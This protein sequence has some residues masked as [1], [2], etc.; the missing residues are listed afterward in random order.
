MCQRR[1][2]SKPCLT[3]RSLCAADA[4]ALF[5]AS[6]EAV[7]GVAGC[8]WY[9]QTHQGRA[10]KWATLLLKTAFGLEATCI[11][12][13]RGRQALFRVVMV[14]RGEGK[15]TRHEVSNCTVNVPTVY[16]L[17]GTGEGAMGST[18]SQTCSWSENLSNHRGRSACGTPQHLRI[19]WGCCRRMGA[20]TLGCRSQQC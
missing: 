9:S 19:E 7:Q 14:C 13:C 4:A 10:A 12:S 2:G 11:I 1:V 15:Q 3:S 8:W 18:R 17:C 20:C 6:Q 16:R 5:R